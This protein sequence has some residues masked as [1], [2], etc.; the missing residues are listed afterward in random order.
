MTDR[1]FERKEADTEKD[2]ETERKR[3]CREEKGELKNKQTN[4]PDR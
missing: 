3:D 2:I 4:K 1:E